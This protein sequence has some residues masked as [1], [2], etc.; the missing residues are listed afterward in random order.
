MSPCF[1]LTD[2]SVPF[3]VKLPTPWESR[4]WKA[5]IRDRERVEPPHVT[6]MHKA[7]AWRLGLRTRQFLDAKPDPREI[8]EEVLEAI[9]AA[10][11]LLHQ[12]WDRMYPE[13]P[14]VSKTLK[15]PKAKRKHK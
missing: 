2:I 1:S 12:E 5:K 6:I 7:K 15:K 13:N 4:G 3:T 11:H 8:P 10:H 9:R 14:V